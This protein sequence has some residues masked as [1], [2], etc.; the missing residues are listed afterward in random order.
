MT[1][2]RRP[3]SL[4][5]AL[6]LVGALASP[7]AAQ[8]VPQGPLT[9]EASAS[10]AAPPA[11]SA[12][13]PLTLPKALA[14][15][16]AA[17]PDLLAAEIDARIAELGLED[18][19]AQQLQLVAE[20][21]TLGRHAQTGILDPTTPQASTDLA[22]ANTNLELRVPLFTGFKISNNIK[23]AEHRQAAAT[24]ARAQSAAQLRFEVTRAFWNLARRE[25]QEAE[26]ASMIAQAEGSLALVR[27]RLKQGT[28][29]PLDV[30]R[31][32]VDLLA[33]QGDLLALGSQTNDARAQ[34]AGW[35][36][37][38]P[39][40]VAIARDAVPEP[41]GGAPAPTEARPPVRIEAGRASLAAAESAVA[42]AQGDRW[43]QLGLVSAYQHGNNPF[44]PNSGVRGVNTTLSGTWDVRLGLSYN[45]FDMGGV[46][47]QIERAENVRK[48][49]EADLDLARRDVATQ[50][51]LTEARLATAGERRRVAEAGARLAERALRYAE[52]R[53]AQGYASQVEV[54]DARRAL[55]R[56]RS[57]RVD[58]TYDL[59][60]AQAERVFVRGQL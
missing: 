52:T 12:A 7:A 38:R 31:A 18:A 35:L 53:W 34:L 21:A 32:E 51:A 14:R 58:A 46:N 36:G 49:A 5:L 28:A 16:L 17:H 37:V 20:V 11:A 55:M 41:E 48:L 27:A 30:D 2:L 57:Q 44:N 3:H 56:A 19:R 42:A 6:A 54:L 26:Q 23:A 60:I 33:A 29:T 9:V 15:A 45:L 10:P 39:D 43:P 1:T 40:E 22:T 47:R 59:Y 25:G 50:A 24:L 4:W 13:V 8:G